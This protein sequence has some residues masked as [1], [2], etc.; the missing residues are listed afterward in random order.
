MSKS[1]KEIVSDRLAELGRN[2]FEAERIGGL[3]KGFVND[4]LIDRKTNIQ[5]TNFE[6]LAKALD[7]TPEQLTESQFGEAKRRS[8]ASGEA[9]PVN[10]TQGVPEYDL[11]G[12]ASYGGGYALPGELSSG[13]AQERI[14][15]QWFFPISWLKGEL[16]LSQQFTDI[17]AVDGPSMLPDLA[18]GD[19]VLIDR[20]NRDPK[21]D[22]IFAIRDG[23]S[24]II[25]HVQLIRNT[26]P[27]R[28]ICRSSNAKYEPFE[29]IID[30]ENVAIIGRVAGR[31]SRL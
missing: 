28:I 9:I 2:K 29:L 20:S 22:A 24:V 6:K 25:K 10:R 31:I 27:P 19:R 12:G 18:P 21:Q 17:I 4:I 23:D 11:R 15:D 16:R 3:K 5:G 8:R 26:D 13:Q 7:W 1:L 14:K 30:G